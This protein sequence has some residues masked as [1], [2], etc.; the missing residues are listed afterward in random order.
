MR[1]RLQIC[2]PELIPLFRRSC[3]HPKNS[4]P[5][6][7]ACRRQTWRAWVQREASLR[8]GN[9]VIPKL[10]SPWAYHQ[11]ARVFHSAPPSRLPRGNTPT[12]KW[13]GPTALTAFHHFPDT[14]G[15]PHFCALNRSSQSGL[16]VCQVQGLLTTSSPEAFS[17]PGHL[18]WPPFPLSPPNAAPVLKSWP[19]S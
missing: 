2:G 8:T 18:P 12:Q 17:C 4:G 9:C 13:G 3:L 5:S 1:F 7:K 6:T 19:G 11:H 14:A 15:S 16:T 10:S